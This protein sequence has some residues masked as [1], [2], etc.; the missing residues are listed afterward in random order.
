MSKGEV[1][2]LP[3]FL[4]ENDGLILIG[5]RGDSDV[6]EEWGKLKNKIMEYA[7]Q[8]AIGFFN[9]KQSLELIEE[10]GSRRWLIN[11]SMNEWSLFAENTEQLYQK[12]LESKNKTQ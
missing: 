5:Y 8:E 11:Y 1:F 2:D 4:Y 9:W 6:T 10:K 3:P 7:K 12:Y